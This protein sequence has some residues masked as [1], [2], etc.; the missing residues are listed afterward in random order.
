VQSE[1]NEG[2]HSTYENVE[3]PL[4][5]TKVFPILTPLPTTALYKFTFN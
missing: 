4:P 2:K 5:S 3:V 1:R